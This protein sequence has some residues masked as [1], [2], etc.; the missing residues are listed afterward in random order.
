MCVLFFF[1]FQC[2]L[3]NQFCKHILKYTRADF[4]IVEGTLRGK[5]QYFCHMTQ[6][7]GTGCDSV[8]CLAICRHSTQL[9]PGSLLTSLASY[10]NLYSIT[11][12]RTSYCAVSAELQSNEKWASCD[13]Y[14][15]VCTQL[16]HTQPLILTA[17][18]WLAYCSECGQATKLTVFFPMSNS[19]LNEFPVNDSI[20]LNLVE[21]AVTCDGNTWTIQD[22]HALFG[23]V[24]VMHCFPKFFMGMLFFESFSVVC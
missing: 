15:R 12:R 24:V 5:I 11:V 4:F 9:T 1:H 7:V 16:A 8:S 21:T 19:N 17:L 10:I 2:F 3:I 13:V 6:S 18:L 14:M 22:W 23:N 20:S